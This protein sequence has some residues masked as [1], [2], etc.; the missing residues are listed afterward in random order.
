MNRGTMGVN[1][2]PKTYITCRLTA[3][4]RDQLRNRTLGN[5]EYGLPFFT[6]R[7]VYEMFVCWLVCLCVSTTPVTSSW[8]VLITFRPC[9]HPLV[10]QCSSTSSSVDPA[11]PRLHDSDSLSPTRSPVRHQPTNSCLMYLFSIS[12]AA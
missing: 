12:T 4:N 1:S 5:R 6:R 8:C 9:S 7:C 11:S 10:A 2:S 3:K